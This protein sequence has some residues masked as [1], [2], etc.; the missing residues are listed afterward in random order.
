MGD[1]QAGEVI[2]GPLQVRSRPHAEDGVV[3]VHFGVKGLPEQQ[4]T[5]TPDAARE[6]AVQLM[7]HFK[8][9]RRANRPGI[10]ETSSPPTDSDAQKTDVEATEGVESPESPDDGPNKDSMSYRPRSGMSGS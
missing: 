1:Q 6:L 7:R 3:T 9:L 4:F 5:L 10:P 8:R 2:Y